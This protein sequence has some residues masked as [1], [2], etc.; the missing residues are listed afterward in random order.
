MSANEEIKDH[1][2]SIIIPTYGRPEKLEKCLLSLN[3]QKYKNFEVILV[4][5]NGENSENGL[6]TEARVGKLESKINY[7]LKYIKLKENQGA[8]IA[9]N[10]GVK[11]SSS[12][13]ITFLD[14]DDEYLED[15]I[16]K[17]IAFM[18]TNDLDLS[19]CGMH[20]NKNG[21]LVES[22]RCYPIGDNLKDFVYDGNAVTA[23]IMVKK[24][25]FEKVGGFSITKKYQDHILV[26]K[27]LE[28][29]PKVGLLNDKLYIYNLHKDGSISKSKKVYDSILLRH[30]YER[31]WI[32][33]LN[34]DQIYFVKFRQ[35]NELIVYSTKVLDIINFY[36]ILDFKYKIKF[37]FSVKL[38]KSIFRRFF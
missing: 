18:L 16:E 31:K 11:A 26:F 32:D 12:D 22:P 3:A 14:D 36:T 29:K 34:S 25:L 4:D 30:K 10:E 17:Q 15:K 20:I 9:R 21:K 6:V 27:I 28:E 24:S 19:L 35:F 33:L 38:Y 7:S 8:C 13:F 1:K 2:V 37:I 23:M 5:D